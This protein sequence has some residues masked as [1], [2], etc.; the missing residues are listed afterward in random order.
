MNRFQ[1]VADLRA[2]FGVK[3][4]CQVLGI[5]RSSFYYWQA[6]AP[7][8]AA[9]QAMG[10]RLTA[11]IAAVHARSDGT[12]GVPRITAEL[13]ENGV[14]PVNHKWIARLM[15]TAGIAGFRIR[16]RRRTTI[17]DPAATKAPDLLGRDFTA[18]EVNT[19]YVGEGH[20]L[21]PGR[22]REVLLPRDRD[23]PRVAPAGR[24]GDRRPHALRAGHRRPGR[25]RADPRAAWPERSCT[26]T[27]AAQ[28]CSRSFAAACRRAGV[29]QSMGAVGSS[30]DNAAAES[31]N[32][33]MKRETLQ[34]RKS[35]SS[36]REARLELFRWL[37][38]YNTVRRHTRLG[39]RSPNAY[40][41]VLNRTST[42]LATA[43]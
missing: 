13:R 8:R 32:A 26:P 35:W 12:Y 33:T 22:R 38:R 9:R 5:S 1:C 21:P 14:G 15:K 6:T 42:T 36:E 20:H 25:G 16:R 30:A 7:A 28:Y 39:H 41:Q 19:K 10:E 23:R 27:A 4:L 18:T 24:V 2:D 37:H 40:E 34:G 31:W 3:R 43:A 17:A 11:K 29:I